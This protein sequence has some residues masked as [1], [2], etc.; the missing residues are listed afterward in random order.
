MTFLC[1]Q[2][3]LLF[4]FNGVSSWYNLFKYWQSFAFSRISLKNAALPAPHKC[5]ASCMHLNRNITATFGEGFAVSAQSL[6]CFPLACNWIETSAE[7]IFI[8]RLTS[9][10][11][12]VDSTFHSPAHGGS[13]TND[14]FTP[15]GRFCFSLTEMSSQ[16]W[17]K[18]K[19][20]GS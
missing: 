14:Q 13:L 7:R 9:F 11:V 19:Q 1:P 15:V 17:G 18:N 8:K 6:K 12:V 3:L 5:H 2:L 20:K 10:S 16:V 4:F